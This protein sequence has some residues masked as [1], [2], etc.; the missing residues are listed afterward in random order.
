MTMIDSQAAAEIAA[1]PLPTQKTL[2]GRRNVPYQF[3]RFIAIN[4]KMIRVIG[5][6]HHAA[7]DWSPPGTAGPA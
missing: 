1:A 3:L 7:G 2:N 6:G 4:L 5:A